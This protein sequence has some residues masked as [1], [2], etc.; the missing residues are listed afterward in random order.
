MKPPPKY[1]AYD[2]HLHTCWSYDA[3]AP[4]E[5]YFKKARELNL[6][7]I[8]ITDHFTMDA[9][10]EIQTIAA[11]Y[12]EIKFIPGAEMTVATSLGSC[13]VV[14]LGLP[15]DPP[16]EL[17]ELFEIYRE[18]Q[19]ATGSAY[20]AAM[21]RLG[22]AFP[23]S[24]RL[25]LL[26]Q[27]RPPATIEKHGITHVQSGVV[28]KN[29]L[30][31]QGCIKSLDEYPDFVTTLRQQVAF[32]DYPDASEV[33]PVIKRAG[34]M[35]A[36]AHPTWYFQQNDVKRMDSF[37][38]ELSLDGIECAHDT[39]PKELTTFYR[40]YCVKHKL[41]STAGSDCHADP[42]NNPCGI[43]TRHHFACHCGA[44]EWLD[45]ILARL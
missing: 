8:A 37:R 35:V 27:Y 6:R 11:D 16:A 31:E 44:E 42:D 3:C 41:F 43:G 19:R 24:E 7:A 38:E 21:R 45:E 9:I 29:Y 36:I 12:P 4:V 23:E 10:P 33:I 25:R 30:L 1:A 40:E 26:Q 28:M 32:P 5:Y 2:L 34:G 17:E 22:F 39:I 13:D 15:I 14:C 18:W 20:S